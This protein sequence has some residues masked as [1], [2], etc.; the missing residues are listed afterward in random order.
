MLRVGGWVCIC[1]YLLLIYDLPRYLGPLEVGMY[2]KI[3]LVR[4]YIRRISRTDSA[5]QLEA[6]A[7]ALPPALSF[8]INSKLCPLY[9]SSTEHPLLPHPLPFTDTNPTLAAHQHHQQLSY[10]HHSLSSRYTHTHSVALPIDEHLSPAPNESLPLCRSPTTRP[11]HASQSHPAPPP[12]C[13]ARPQTQP[14]NTQLC[15]AA[16]A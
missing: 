3:M 2:S 8:H 13:P 6:R 14:A 1:T 10:T 15:G 5:H 12:S 9:P 11:P 7:P 4:L 16:R